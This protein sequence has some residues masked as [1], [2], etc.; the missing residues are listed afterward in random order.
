MGRLF[1]LLIVALGLAPG[2]WWRSPRA[3][4]DHRQI[5]HV[6]RLAVPREVPGDEIEVLGAWRLRSPND[7]FS[8]YSALLAMGD[9]TLLALSDHGRQLRFTP[10]GTAPARF[11]LDVFANLIDAD[12]R[13]LDL[14][15]ATRDPE[16]GT[17]WAA[18]EFGNFIER[19]DT[20][21]APHGRVEPAAMQ[22]WPGNQGPEAMVRLSD[23]RFIVLAEGSPRW[24]AADAPGMLFPRDPLRG[25]KAIEFDF[26]APEGFAPVDM[27]ELPD[28]RVLILLRAVRWELPPRF[29]GKLVVADPARIAAGEPWPWEPVADLVEP[30]PMDNYEGLAVEPGKDG[31]VLWLISDDNKA[32]FQRTLLLKLMWRPNAKA[33]GNARAPR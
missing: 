27:A 4:R 5:L 25:G 6:D 14:E 29:E 8:G 33:R 1:L 2:T 9:G 28:G 20:R 17:V 24:F 3:P 13:Q 15:A 19:Y 18:Y 26:R 12:Q 10:P 7:D 30:L 23:G 22:P 32:T 16:T 11:R 31:L 21:F